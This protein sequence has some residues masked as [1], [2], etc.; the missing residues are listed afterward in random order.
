MANVE[1]K[2]VCEHQA[3]LDKYSE[4]LNFFQ[5]RVSMH[6]DIEEL[7]AK[8]HR[9]EEALA[10][11]SEAAHAATSQNRYDRERRSRMQRLSMLEQ[12]VIALRKVP[13]LSP[14]YPRASPVPRCVDSNR[15]G[16]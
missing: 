10:M 7:V 12:R 2:E 4:D 11:A 13:S 9:I 6:K 14:S 15:A 3:V 1:A 5:A 16:K 8:K